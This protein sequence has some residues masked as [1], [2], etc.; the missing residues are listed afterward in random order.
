MQTRHQFITADSADISVLDNESIDLIVTSPPYPMIA[1][2]DGIFSAGNREVEAAFQNSD[3]VSAFDGCHLLLDRIWEECFRV[4]KNGSFLCI[5]IGDAVRKIGD[6]FRLFPNHSRITSA[7]R[8]LGF[9][10]LPLILWRKPT[11]APTK[12]MGSG[13]YPA[14][15]YVTLEHE[16]ILIF[17]K[18]GKYDFSGADKDRRRKS[19][20]FWEERN[21]WF[22]DVW[23]FRGTGQILSGG[24]SRERSA[25]FP[26]ELPYRLI[27]MYSLY[28]DTV[29][30]PFSG[31]GT[32][33]LAAAGTGRNSIGID[34]DAALNTD[35]GNILTASADILNSR[36]TARMEGHAAFAAER[37]KAGK[38]LKYQNK[39]HGVPV[40]TRQE[41]LLELWEIT[42]PP[43]RTDG[44]I[45]FRYRPYRKNQ[46]ELFDL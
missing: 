29:L 3:G 8:R 25:A 28:E 46:R 24:K 18:G 21:V 37:I 16:Y 31:T 9:Q 15:A 6:D 33:S 36:V 12:F 14:G 41:E 26:L 32:T 19:A 23:D 43:E 38:P 10:S 4:L 22:S 34:T 42:V 2:W 20:Y 5:N 7:C 44:G 17:R 30:D 39:P 1:M 13:M 45:I 35:A 27:C 11:N 40:V